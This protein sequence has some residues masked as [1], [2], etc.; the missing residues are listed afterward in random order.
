MCDTSS[1]KH[2]VSRRSVLGAALA[3]AGGVVAS[4]LWTPS[5]GAAP[6]AAAGNPLQPVL[7]D[8]ACHSRSGR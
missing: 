1:S 4:T 2:P 3:G 5:A 6:L 8:R 7:P